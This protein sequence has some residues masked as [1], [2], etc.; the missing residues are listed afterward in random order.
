VEVALSAVVPDILQ[1]VELSLD[2]TTRQTLLAEAHRRTRMGPAE[3]LRTLGA[4]VAERAGR[5]LLSSAGGVVGDAGLTL[6]IE[7]H[8]PPNPAHQRRL[9]ALG[10]ADRRAEDFILARRRVVRSLQHQVAM[11]EARLPASRLGNGS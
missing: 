2:L 5:V 10:E 8:T 11:L 4:F 3:A 6:F 1:Q 7:S 9:A